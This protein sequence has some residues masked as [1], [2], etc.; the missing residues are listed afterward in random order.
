MQ[1]RLY[2]A[3]ILDTTHNRAHG[4]H[5]RA[6]SKPLARRE[7]RKYCIARQLVDVSYRVREVPPR[8]PGWHFLVCGIGAILLI[9]GLMR[10]A[11]LVFN[12]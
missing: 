11:A 5:F 3:R 2:Y 1:M 12:A 10:F 4:I 7:V 6:Q 8:R 9:L